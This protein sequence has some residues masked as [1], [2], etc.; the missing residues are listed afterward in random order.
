M[1][2]ALLAVDVQNYF[3]TENAVGIP[4]KIAWY[5]EEEQSQYDVV[6][7]A[8]FRN[9][10]ESN[11]HTLLGFTEVTQSP[12]T[13]IHDLLQPFIANDTVFEKTT[14]SAMKSKPLL[15]YLQTHNIQALDICGISFDACVLATAY[16]AFDLGYTIKIL[17]NLCSVSSARDGLM[18]ATRLIVGRNLQKR[19]N[20]FQR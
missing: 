6:L 19:E 2:K 10:P 1:K 20:R 5:I 11:F 17:E 3:V 13:D 15:E 16:D 18:E 8:K 7:F 4:Q 9:D 12:A 14:Y